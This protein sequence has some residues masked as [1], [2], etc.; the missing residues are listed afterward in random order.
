M[1]CVEISH[2]TGIGPL[3]PAGL[4]GFA[5]SLGVPP[6]QPLHGGSGVPVRPKL[7]L[8]PEHPPDKSNVH[9]APM[10]PRGSFVPLGTPRAPLTLPH[11]GIA[12]DPLGNVVSAG[13][14]PASAPPVQH[15]GSEGPR[16]AL[17]LLDPTAASVRP[18][19]PQVSYMYILMMYV[20]WTA[21][22]LFLLSLIESS[23]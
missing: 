15:I 5:E 20:P 6:N 12:T 18:V 9:G 17:P 7:G 23:S 22:T 11:L 4:R 3:L 19:L 2:A 1:Y 10:L 8:P 13:A 21:T 14:R 16:A